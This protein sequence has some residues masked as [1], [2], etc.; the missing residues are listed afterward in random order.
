MSRRPGK[1]RLRLAA[2]TFG[3][4]LAA[5]AVAAAQAE[6]LIALAR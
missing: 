2:R 4:W 5:I 6:M 1:P 3:V